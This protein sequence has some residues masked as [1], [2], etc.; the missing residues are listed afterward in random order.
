MSPLTDSVVMNFSTLPNDSQ[1][2][3]SLF[4]NESK[5]GRDRERKCLRATKMMERKKR[6]KHKVREGGQRTDWESKA[7]RDALS[8]LHFPDRLLLLFL[9]SV[10]DDVA[11]VLVVNIASHIWGEGGPQILHL[12]C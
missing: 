6:K 5:I 3:K 2:D 7:A 8:S 11:D 12:L 4:L 10:C 9:L 1:R